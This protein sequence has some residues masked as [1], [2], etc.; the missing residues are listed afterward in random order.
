MAD[1]RVGFCGRYYT[2][3]LLQ[4]H[5]KVHYH[6]YVGIKVGSA[7][8]TFTRKPTHFQLPCKLVTVVIF[9]VGLKTFQHQLTACFAR[10]EYGVGFKD[11]FSGDFS[12]MLT[13]GGLQRV[14]VNQTADLIKN[15]VLFL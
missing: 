15:I 9:C 13:Q 6:W 1:P 14:I 10:L 12:Q 2:R 7:G 3:T 11:I 8:Y 5:D 4:F